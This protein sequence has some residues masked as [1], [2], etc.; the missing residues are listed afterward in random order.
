M[1]SC[2]QLEPKML[3]QVLSI[4]VSY[5]SLELRPRNMN[6]QPINGSGGAPVDELMGYK[7]SRN[8]SLDSCWASGLTTFDGSDPVPMLSIICQFWPVMFTSVELMEAAKG[9]MS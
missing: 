3:L 5:T 9:S 7:V 2:E 1:I 8:R 6:E 4:D